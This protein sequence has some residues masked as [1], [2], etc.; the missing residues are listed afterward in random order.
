MRPKIS[1]LFND[2]FRKLEERSTLQWTEIGVLLNMFSP[3]D[4]LKL[5]SA[6]ETLKKGV[7]R[8]WQKEKHIN[9]IIY[10]P[11][12]ASEY[13]LAYVLFKNGNAHRRY[14]FVENAAASALEPGHVKSCLVIA[15][16][17]DQDDLPYH[18]IS[19]CKSSDD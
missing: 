1:K 11:P 9:A 3:D 19:L 17:I 15:K 8:T 4:Q 2:I 10:V 18:Y 16:N 6:V 13:A 5:A 14:E 7:N 12:E